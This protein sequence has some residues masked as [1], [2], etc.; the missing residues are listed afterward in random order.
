MPEWSSCRLKLLIVLCMIGYCT[1]SNVL[2]DDCTGFLVCS[3]VSQLGGQNAQKGGNSL[4]A[5][6]ELG[7]ELC[8]AHFKC[9]ATQK[10]VISLLWQSAEAGNSGHQRTPRGVRPRITGRPFRKP[11]NSEKRAVCRKCEA[12]RSSCTSFYIMTY[13]VCGGAYLA[14]GNLAST[15]CNVITLPRSVDCFLNTF[16][17]CYMK[18]CGLIGF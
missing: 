18:D 8:K 3:L 2:T 14:G 5:D 12:K 15:A 9:N 4:L 6:R 11:P 1:A 17:N 10:E 16:L 13:G 7:N